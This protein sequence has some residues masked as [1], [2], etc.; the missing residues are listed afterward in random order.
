[1]FQ[2]AVTIGDLELFLKRLKSFPVLG[3]RLITL[4]NQGIAEN[5]L[6]PLAVMPKVVAQLRGLSKPHALTARC[7]RLSRGSQLVGAH[8]TA[9]I[10]TSE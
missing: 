7:G 2:P 10:S 3:N 8:P 5:R 6:P 4:L 9:G 1:V